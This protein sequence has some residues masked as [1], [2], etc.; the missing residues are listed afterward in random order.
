MTAGSTE[1]PAA[2]PYL[3]YVTFR[4]FLDS[5]KQGLPQC[6]DA[7][8]MPSLS[9]QNKALV[10]AAFRFLGLTDTDD[11]P[12]SCLQDLVD[13]E[14][15]ER[16]QLWAQTLREAFVFLFDDPSFDLAKA[17]KNQFHT[18]FVSQGLATETARKAEVFFLS[19][20]REAAIPVST[21]ITKGTRPG[22]QNSTARNRNSGKRNLSSV[23]EPERIG[24]EGARR[25]AQPSQPPLPAPSVPSPRE[26]MIQGLF[27]DLPPEG[28]TWTQAEKQRW[29]KMAEA[30]IER[31]IPIREE[32]ADR[33]S[34][35]EQATS[36]TNSG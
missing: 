30:V 28:Q 8:T 4:N 16:E 35:S 25:T 36:E 10:R 22:R 29:F 6:I 9:G 24:N 1:K 17:T 3:S 14:G 32:C 26:L 31:F 7:S 19:A 13:A 27:S 20:A 11:I 5:L 34:K 18:K 33:P 15:K 23:S 12:T 21:Y 2:P